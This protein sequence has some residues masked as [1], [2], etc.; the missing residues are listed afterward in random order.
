MRRFAALILCLSLVTVAC[1]DGDD[2]DGTAAAASA[3]VMARVEA[4]FGEQP[5]LDPG[6]VVVP[7]GCR[8]VIE[9]DEYGFETEIVACDDDLDPA[10]PTE[11]EEVAPELSAWGGSGDARGIARNLRRVLV[12][13]TGCNTPQDL[14]SLENLVAASPAEIRPLMQAAVADLRRSADLC[15]VD[16]AGWQQGLEDALND[17]DDVVAVFEEA[18]DE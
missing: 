18:L 14:I 12:E 15:N 1:S 6:E 10:M 9:K 5:S 17:L 8:L 2:P 16:A 7:E 11:G 3:E 13:Q 4:V